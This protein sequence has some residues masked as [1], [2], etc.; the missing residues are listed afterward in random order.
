LQFRKAAQPA[1]IQDHV[2]RIIIG[3]KIVVDRRMKILIG[4]DGSDYANAALKDLLRAGLPSDAQAIVL[5][6]PKFSLTEEAK[7]ERNGKAGL[8]AASP[9]KGLEEAAAM[10]KKACEMIR[11][12]FPAWEVRAELAVGSTARIVAK[13]ASQWNPNLI[14]LGLQ[15][16]VEPGHH[17]GGVPRQIAVAA[18]YSVRVARG[19]NAETDDAPRV[20]LCVDGSPYTDAVVSAVAS[21]DWPKGA[22][23]RI[24]TVVN[25]FDY[26]IPEFVDKAMERAK[27]LHRIIANELDRTPAFIS[28]VIAEGE[29]E[30][31]ILK[32]A[33]EWRPDCIFLAPHKR[34]RFSRFLLGGVSGTVVARARCAVELARSVKPDVRRDSFLQAPTANPV[35]D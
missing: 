32:I 25:P 33:D 18:K 35:F 3:E 23:V 7:T 30:R 22:E 27:A 24:L 11:E 20:L 12:H 8:L 6:I 26:S 14:V 5:S 15:S 13:K 9:E 17:F 34:N 4:Y 29:P 10:A 21:R 1:L 31:V 16:G 2:W 28:S 19:F